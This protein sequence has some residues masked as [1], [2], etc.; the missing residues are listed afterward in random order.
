MGARA[1][2]CAHR[3]GRAKPFEHSGILKPSPQ[4]HRNHPKAEPSPP[5]PRR[6]SRGW[7]PGGRIP[8]IRARRAREVSGAPPEPCRSPRLEDAPASSQHPSQSSQAPSSARRPCLTPHHFPGGFGSPAP[9][10]PPLRALPAAVGSPLSQVGPAGLSPPP[11]PRSPQPWGPSEPDP[12]VGEVCW[13]PGRDHPALRPQRL[14]TV[15][16]EGLQDKNPR[17][18]LLFQKAVPSPLGIN[19]IKC[20][21]DKSW[22]YPTYLADMALKHSLEVLQNS[23]KTTQTLR[24]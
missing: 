7:G 14:L 4:K 12:G 3:A 23:G 5:A 24:R 13:E 18:W 16:P 10:V 17:F 9:S 21:S 15:L 20:T 2:P 19:P 11:G 6:V 22:C 1:E 8:G